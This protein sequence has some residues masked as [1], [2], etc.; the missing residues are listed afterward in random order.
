[1]LLIAISAVSTP[2]L[3]KNEADAEWWEE[4]PLPLAQQSFHRLTVLRSAA[5]LPKTLLQK[6]R[7]SHHVQMKPPGGL[8]VAPLV[9]VLQFSFSLTG[10]LC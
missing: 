7:M 9:I 3:K 6:A 4:L 10:A 5:L 1:M 8:T 2:K